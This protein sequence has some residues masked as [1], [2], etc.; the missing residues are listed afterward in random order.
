MAD[1]NT[2]VKIDDPVNRGHGE[3]SVDLTVAQFDSGMAEVI[4]EDFSAL[5]SDA[6][7][8]RLVFANRDQEIDHHAKKSMWAGV[9]LAGMAGAAAAQPQTATVNNSDGTSSTITY[10]DPVAQQ[11][12]NEQAAETGHAIRQRAIDAKVGLLHRNTVEPGQSVSGTVFF[13]RVKGSNVKIGSKDRLFAVDI[14]I[15]GVVFRFQ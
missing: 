5:F 8:T 7:H 1:G 3:F 13:K 11:R 10:T 14:P 12:A 6:A 4:P 15:N 9:L 2:V